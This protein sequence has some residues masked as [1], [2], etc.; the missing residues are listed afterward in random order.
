MSLG[1]NDRVGSGEVR[2]QSSPCVEAPSVNLRTKDGTEFVIPGSLL[3]KSPELQRLSASTQTLQLSI[4]HDIGY[5]LV[6]FL[7]TDAYQCPEAK[8]S[9][10]GERI[11][12]EFAISA[13]V[14]A[15]ARDYRILGLEEL[16]K[17]QME[18]LG[19]KLH[20]ATTIDLIRNVYP[21]PAADDAWLSNYLKSSL[22]AVFLRNPSELLS[23]ISLSHGEHRTSSIGD[24]LFNNLVE[25]MLEQTIISQDAGHDQN[26]QLSDLSD[27]LKQSPKI[28]PAHG[29]HGIGGGK[30]VPKTGNEDISWAIWGTLKKKERRANVIIR[31]SQLEQDQRSEVKLNSHSILESKEADSWA[32][33]GTLKKKRRSGNIIVRKSTPKP[34]QNQAELKSTLEAKAV[35]DSWARWGTLKRKKTGH[36]IIRKP[37]LGPEQYPQCKDDMH[38]KSATKEADE[39]WAYW[40]TLK[41]KNRIKKAIIRTS[42]QD[43][44][45]E[46]EQT[47]GNGTVADANEES[48]LWTTW[49]APKR[50]RKQRS[51]VVIS[52]S[53][54]D[55]DLGADCAAGAG[56][57]FEPT[58]DIKPAADV[59]P[60]DD[61]VGVTLA[62]RES[63]RP[64]KMEHDAWVFARRFESE[65]QKNKRIFEYKPRPD[66]R[67]ETQRDWMLSGPDAVGQFVEEDCILD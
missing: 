55:A 30:D 24:L 40:G 64:E 3:R 14:Y 36:V 7:L 22:K 9:S 53:G 28:T 49:A 10:T 39:S 16:A 67:I 43:L 13:G 15:L 57:N 65:S 32:V 42:L 34:T 60:H 12:S 23:C 45:Q 5:V 47:C 26:S 25:V 59:D 63:N 54:Q 17:R 2:P 41:K 56:A 21:D 33:W 35:D 31:R 66:Q 48:E 50:T 11:A 62:S 44:R 6:H 58:A 27:T 1:A 29:K 51:K 4:T 38:A 20:L 18:T 19:S 52:E 8:A 61:I 37:S 46:P